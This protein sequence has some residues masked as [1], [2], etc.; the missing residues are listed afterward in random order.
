MSSQYYSVKEIAQFQKAMRDKR[1]QWLEREHARNCR[2]RYCGLKTPLRD[3]NFSQSKEANCESRHATLDHIVPTARGGADNPSNWALACN[4]CN[5]L[6]GDMS[7]T[8]YRAI[9]HEEGILV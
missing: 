7:E 1:R 3:R 4:V 6:K 2:C 5:L 9:L 8:E